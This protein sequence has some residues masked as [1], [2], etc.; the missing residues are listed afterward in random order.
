MSSSYV[1]PLL[2]LIRFSF[3]WSAAN[4]C[5]WDG[6]DQW[7]TISLFQVWSKLLS[8]ICAAL[9]KN[10]SHTCVTGSVTDHQEE[11]AGFS[12]LLNDTSEGPGIRDS[13]TFLPK[14]AT[15]AIC[16][17]AGLPDWYCSSHVSSAQTCAGTA[18][19]RESTVCPHFAVICRDA[20]LLW[21]VTFTYGDSK[22][23]RRKPTLSNVSKHTTQP[24]GQRIQF[25]TANM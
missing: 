17:E 20:A 14:P 24:R 1:P 4:V 12:S 13:R 21:D 11:F 3:S 5:L 23:G 15:W 2:R 22:T 25:N 10:F 19:P 18:D 9:G 7:R 6:A 16:S 8:R